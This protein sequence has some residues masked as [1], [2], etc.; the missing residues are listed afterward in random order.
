MKGLVVLASSIRARLCRQPTYH[1]ATSRTFSLL[2]TL[3]DSRA[4]SSS[5]WLHIQSRLRLQKESNNTYWIARLLKSQSMTF[6]WADLHLH[7]QAIEQ[8]EMAGLLFFI[9]SCVRCIV[10]DII[11]TL[12]KSTDMYE[13]E[14]PG[15]VFGT[16]NQVESVAD[17][18]R[19]PKFP[20][21]HAETQWHKRQM[22]QGQRALLH[23]TLLR[24]SVQRKRIDPV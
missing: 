4:W 5:N 17:I 18:K 21:H 23:W 6:L 24:R 14:G 13:K 8:W 11:Q 1:T 3:D 22:R 2:C 19:R 10:D 15:R 12:E 9:P 7:V 16:A 20:P